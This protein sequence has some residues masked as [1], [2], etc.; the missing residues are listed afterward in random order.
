MG[1]LSPGRIGKYMGLQ[2]QHDPEHL[3]NIIMQLIVTFIEDPI[4][5]VENLKE[6][7]KTLNCPVLIE[8]TDVPREELDEISLDLAEN[9]SSVIGKDEERILH[10]AGE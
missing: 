3:A 1:L 6:L 2:G 7:S 9:H 4:N 10:E 5:S 8:G